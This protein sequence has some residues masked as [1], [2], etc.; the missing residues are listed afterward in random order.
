MHTIP[1]DSIRQDLRHA[2]RR[3]RREPGVAAAAVLTIGLAV[4]LASAVYSVAASVLLAPFPYKQPDRLVTVWRTL[5][6]VDIVPLSIPDFVDLRSRSRTLDQVAGV[7]REWFDVITAGSAEYA[8]SYS[9]TANLFEVLGVQ[10]LIGRTLHTGDDAP[11]R[12]KV[13]VLDEGF[14][15]RAFGAD[16]HVVG[17]RVR[18]AGS[19]NGEPGSDSYEVVGVVSSRARLFYRL[20]MPVDLYVPRV[21]TRSDLGEANRIPPVF[22]PSR[23]CVPA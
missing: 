12:E 14:W 13:V 15:R 5:Q 18:L 20:P 3:M 11:G 8:D 10:P 23:A 4:G 7:E 19:G 1:V 6:D 21:V 9:V 2:V 16:P 22:L 17:T